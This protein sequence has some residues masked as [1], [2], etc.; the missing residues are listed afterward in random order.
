MALKAR[1][2]CLEILAK[3]AIRSEE[4]LVDAR[5]CVNHATIKNRMIRTAIV[6]SWSGSRAT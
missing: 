3:A 6:G 1:L 5:P 4:K 2:N